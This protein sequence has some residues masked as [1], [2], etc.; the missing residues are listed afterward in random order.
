MGDKHDICTDWHS[1]FDALCVEQGHLDNAQLAARYC[2]ILR[3]TTHEAYESAVKNLSNWRQG[4][5]TPSRRNFRAL[6]LL[7]G[8]D[9]RPDI[10][11]QWNR[12]YE[13]AQRRRPASSESEG[14][15]D[16]PV[17]PREP[18]A[19]STVRWWAGLRWGRRATVA[20]GTLAILVAVVSGATFAP[21]SQ[22][23]APQPQTDL[24]LINSPLA[25]V[26]SRKI[27]MTDQQVFWSQLVRLKVGESAVIH[28]RRAEECG[29][30]PPS[31]AEVLSELPEVPTGEWSDGGVGFRVSRA[32]KGATPVRAVVFTAARPGSHLFV[33]YE[34]PVTI[35][36]DEF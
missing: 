12:L 21:M 18:V 31:W 11:A 5:H 34:D 32:C 30:Q 36:V 7:L 20:F 10:R 23:S 24:V 16:T 25:Q 29:E 4:I 14:H 17:A 9:G 15:H 2:D 22:V 13:E 26:G 1:L 35:I 19:A 28:G 8:I 6:T 3:R 27:D 33:L